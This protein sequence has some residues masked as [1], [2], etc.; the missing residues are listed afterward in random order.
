MENIIR[1]HVAERASKIVIYN[2]TV[3]LCGQVGIPDTPLQ[4]Q[5]KE[6]LSRVDTLL[7]DAGTDKS[8]ILS[9][10]VYLSDIRHFAEFNEIWDAWVTPDNTP[11]RT[12]VE[13]RIGHPGIFCEVTVVAALP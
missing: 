8:H 12:C 9:T 5:A 11:T 10:T 7:E 6:M 1:K 2:G 4:D 13:A 3:H